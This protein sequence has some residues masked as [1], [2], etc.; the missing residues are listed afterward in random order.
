MI[1]K[2]TKIIFLDKNDALADELIGGIPLTKNEIVNVTKNGVISAY[3]VT[4][5]KIEL[6]YENED[7]IANI[8]YTLKKK[9]F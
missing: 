4:D 5:K 2:N 6:I 3:E 8:T 1:K 9:Q 7:Q